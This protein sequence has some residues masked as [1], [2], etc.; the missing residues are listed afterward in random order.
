MTFNLGARLRAVM[1][2]NNISQYKLAKL[3]GVSQSA[4]SDIM[5]GK[6]SPTV[7]TL[8]KIC[9]ALHITF[10]HSRKYITRLQDK[11]PTIVEN[12]RIFE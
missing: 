9:A 10:L 4:I 6:K 11:M 8:Q 12:T 1:E 3:T 7:Q 5:A 2:I